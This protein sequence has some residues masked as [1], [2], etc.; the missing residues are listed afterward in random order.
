MENA[1]LDVK[2]LLTQYYTGDGVINAVH[3][4]S[5]SIPKGQTVCLVGESGCGKSAVAMSIMGLI[6][7]GSG[8]IKDGEILFEGKD[9][10]KMKK[11]ELRQLRGNDISM[12]F[13]EPMTSL[14]PVLT[15]GGQIIEPLMEHELIS[16]KEAKKRALELI[17]LVGIGRAEEI[18]N[19]YPH[20]LSGGMLQR[21]MIAI[22]LACSPNLL[23]A[24]EPT[25][26]LDVTIQAQILDLLR[27]LKEQRDMSMLLITHDLGVVAEVA[28][29]VIVMYAGRVIEEG[30][31][32]ELFQNPKHPY[33]KGLLKAK[34]V[35]NQRQ[36]E[37][38][39]IAGQVPNLATLTPSCYF[40]ERCEQCMAIC[41][42]QMPEIKDL[43]NGQRVA[44]WLYEEVTTV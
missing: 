17:E 35:I 15:I 31:V 6:D 22:A 23:I 39:T 37:L 12:I 33:T 5:F 1:V 44:C 34:P 25:T 2:N 3:D 4:V 38:Y 36:E 28:D 29:Y 19:S 16:K 42:E 14:N 18:F 43:D 9:L 10:L 8:G 27:S 20:E 26:A 24:D 30:P 21:I 13:Q 40:S 41:N 32:V 7:A 11:H